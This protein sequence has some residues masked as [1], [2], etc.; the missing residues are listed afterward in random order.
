MMTI[1]FDR[2]RLTLTPHVLRRGGLLQALLKSVYQPLKTIYGAFTAYEAKESGERQYGPTVK[3]LKAAIANHLGIAVADVVF[4]DV[5]NRDPI[6]IRR[7]SD[8][9]S[10]RVALK[11]Q[12][13][14]ATTRLAVWSDDMIWWNREFIVSLPQTYNNQY[15]QRE[16]E[17]ILDRWK[18][19]ASRYTIIYRQ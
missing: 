1:D 18:M 9:R 4:S 12:S 2:L 3:Q 7:Q 17:T 19:A 10:T 8:G 13:A 6:D 14:A 15:T 5:S 16:I 11:S